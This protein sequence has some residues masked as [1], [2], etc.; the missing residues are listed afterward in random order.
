MEFD[1]NW[2]IESKDI[3]FKLTTGYLKSI[4]SHIEWLSG[5]LYGL[6]LNNY[7]V[8]Y[9]FDGVFFELRYQ[10]VTWNFTQNWRIESRD[11]LFKSYHRLS[12]EYFKSYRIAFRVALWLDLLY[13]FFSYLFILRCL[14][15]AAISKYYMGFDTKLQDWINRYLIQTYHKLSQ[16]YFKW[17]RILFRVALWLDFEQ[18]S[19]YL[20]FY[21]HFLELR[22]DN[23]TW[24]LIQIGGLNQKISYLNLPQVISRV[25]QVI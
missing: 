16:G 21:R 2:R 24:N 9:S 17:D 14:F 25:F 1:T 6:I 19:S 4:S 18:L 5:W 7:P 23:V 10:N 3:L 20:F 8:T 12:Q 22:Y 11:I 15:R 13:Q